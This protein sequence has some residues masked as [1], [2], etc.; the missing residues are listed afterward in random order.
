MGTLKLLFITNLLL[1][2]RPIPLHSA[3]TYNVGDPVTLFVNKIGPLHNPSETYQYYEL[4]FCRPDQVVKKKENLGEVLN[5]DR[6]ANSL[7]KLDFA[8]NKTQAVICQQKLNRV[9]IAKFKDAIIND[10]YYQMYYDDL[11]L[12]AFIG[13]VEDE[14]LTGDNKGPKYFLFTHVQFNAL[15]NGNQVLEISAFCD[16]SHVVEIAEGVDMEIKFTYSVLWNGVSTPY[17]NRMDR[18]SRA[19]LQPIIHKTHWFSFINSTVILILLMGL[20]TVL[21]MR[22]LKNDLRKWS[23]GGDEEE[24]KEV[25]WKYIHGDIFRCP[26]NLPLFSAVLGCGTQLVTMVAIL[27]ILAFIGVIYPY[28]RGTLPSSIFIAYILTSAVAGYSSSSFCSQYAEI[29]WRRSALLAGL[30]FFSP[31]LFTG[32]ILNILASS[33]GATRALPLGTIFVIFLVYTFVSIPLLILGGVFGHR[34]NS[35]LQSSPVT[36]KCP[37]EIPSLSFYRKTPAQMF[38]G[39]LLPFCAIAPELHN[40]CATIWGHKIYTSP[41]ILLVTFI[42]LII[43]TAMLSVG[44]TYFQLAVEDHDWWWRSVLR[45]GSTALFM[46]CYCIYFYFKSNMSGILQTSFFLGYSTCMCYAFFL[47]LGTV[48]FQASLLFVRRIYHAAK[49]E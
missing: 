6:L 18:Y 45:G 42:I 19:S 29:G 30:L 31:F 44:L 10:F 48:S 8:V 36:K 40:L 17:E 7:Y 33:F 49:S 47:M 43:L 14:S 32:F 20:L 28:S 38:L 24:E 13:K 23:I 41:G 3:N 16:P 27:F 37:R 1:L 34:Y 46:F 2:L 39:G 12:W 5:G 21:F 26:S 35:D 15:Y 4:A 9:D 22:H 25:G 11:P